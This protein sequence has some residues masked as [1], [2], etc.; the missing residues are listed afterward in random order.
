MKTVIDVPVGSGRHVAAIRSIEYDT[1]YYYNGVGN[2]IIDA[3]RVEHSDFIR[4]TLE[5]IAL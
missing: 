3:V 1:P 4:I 2:N 5:A